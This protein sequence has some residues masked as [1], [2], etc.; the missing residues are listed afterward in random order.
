MPIARE[1]VEGGAHTLDVCMALTER[2]DEAA[3]V[4]KLVKK[5]S[6]SVEAP[7][8]IDSTEANVIEQALAAVPGAALVNSINLE[9]GRER[10]EAVMPLVVKYG[11][12]GIAVTI[13]ETG[14]TQTRER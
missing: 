5:L 11:A 4:R 9:N 3:M 12:A 14:M 2:T 6:L 10:I 8:V 13:N 1:Q 7:L